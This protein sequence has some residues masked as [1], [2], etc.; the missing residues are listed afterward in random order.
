[1]NSKALEKKMIVPDLVRCLSGH[2]SW[3]HQP[4]PP[5]MEDLWPH[6]TPLEVMF[7]AFSSAYPKFSASQPDN[8]LP[9]MTR[10]SMLPL[11][12]F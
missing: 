4:L 3:S 2:K 7:T 1:M 8:P 9:C 10:K 12:L 11:C 6:N 5:L